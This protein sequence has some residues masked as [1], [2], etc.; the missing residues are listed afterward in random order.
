M[1]QRTVYDCDG[2]S[3]KAV[4][5]RRISAVV[6]RHADGA[7]GMEDITEVLDLCGDCMRV[8]M[9]NFVDALDYAGAKAWVSEVKAK[10]A[11]YLK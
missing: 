8:E 9:N 6:D 5:V 4:D 2:C 3:K 11:R 1:A 7:G 10:R